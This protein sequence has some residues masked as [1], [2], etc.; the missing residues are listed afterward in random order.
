[1]T[2][3][4]AR[5]FRATLLVLLAASTARGAWVALRLWEHDVP[6]AF[7]AARPYLTVAASLLVAV[8][9]LAALRNRTWGLLVLTAASGSF[10]CVA[11][12]GIAPLPYAI[13]A[14]L[15]GLALGL[16][17]A[18]IGSRHGAALGAA[19]VGAALVAA[20]ASALAGPGIAWLAAAP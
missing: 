7:S 11:A 6:L 14:L 2:P 19:T 8:G 15:G 10:A 9:S 16:A 17:A 12:I 13:V 4:R 5:L 18:P 20:A 3:R 1:M